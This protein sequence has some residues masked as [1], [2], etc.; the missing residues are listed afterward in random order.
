MFD[1][2]THEVWQREHDGVFG[3][4]GRD[5]WDCCSARACKSTRPTL[6]V[7]RVH[8]GA[9]EKRFEL[10]DRT[11]TSWATASTNE[12]VFTGHSIVIDGGLEIPQSRK[13]DFPAIDCSY[14][15]NIGPRRGYGA[16]HLELV[17]ACRALDRGATLGHER[18]IKV[19]GGAAALA[20]DFHGAIESFPRC[21]SEGNK[22]AGI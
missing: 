19:V 17:A 16:T 11:K 3:A 13:F 5:G 6:G 18:V 1:S 9:I 12:H 20:G 2:S 22:C 7:W 15:P 8:S 21:A 14:N 4:L 10:G